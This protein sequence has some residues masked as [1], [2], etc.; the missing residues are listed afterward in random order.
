MAEQDHISDVR[1]YTEATHTAYADV[2]GAEP[3][4]AGD[5]P[6]VPER[7]NVKYNWRT[8]L[9][10]EGWKIGNI[11]ISGQWTD[12]SNPVIRGRLLVIVGMRNAPAWARA[13]AEAQMPTVGLVDWTAA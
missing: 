12:P 10:D 2:A 9:G 3:I 4:K 6:I 1:S 5:R 13:F 8:Q 11:E 7:I